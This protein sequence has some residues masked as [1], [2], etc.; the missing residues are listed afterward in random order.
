MKL[1]HA[2]GF[3][4]LTATVS[5]Q[6][7]TAFDGHKWQAPYQLT[8]PEGWGVERFLLPPGFAPQIQYKG[9]EDIRFTPGWANAKSNEYWSY[10]F[11]WYIEGQLV[12]DAK[13]LDT[14]LSAYYTGLVRVNGANIPPEKIIPVEVTVKPGSMKDGPTA[15]RATVKMTDYMTQQPIT[16]SIKVYQRTCATQNKTFVFFTIFPQFNK[17]VWKTLSQ[18][19][20]DTQCDKK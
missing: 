9:V 7:S 4:F 11:V 3:F 5:A 1:L 16:L 12:F 15:Y 13:M 10:A 17:T 20:L 14:C 2:I 6:D 19:R 8:T 18:L